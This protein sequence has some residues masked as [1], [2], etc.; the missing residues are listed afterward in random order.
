[1]RTREEISQER[2][3]EVLGTALQEYISDQRAQEY[4]HELL[5]N[6]L[7]HLPKSS[8]RDA[9][10]E[11]W[12]TAAVF[13]NSP[14]KEGKVKELKTV[15][16]TLLCYLGLFPEAVERQQ[17]GAPG[18]SWYTAV[19]AS[20]Y[21]LAAK[22]SEELGQF[23]LHQELF[24]HLGEEFLR[25][26]NAVQLTKARIDY[27]ATGELRFHLLKEQELP[28]PTRRTEGFYFGG[29]PYSAE[30]KVIIYPKG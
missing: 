30:G 3:G 8:F 6:S 28:L 15:G 19:G 12:N 17:H 16:D 5:L 23:S 11:L 7:E 21:T 2:L 22:L 29:I 26:V 25:F 1:M 4:V 18:I 14:K 24:Q 10:T 27:S 20:S 9:S 13:P